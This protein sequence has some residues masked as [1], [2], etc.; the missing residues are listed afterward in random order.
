M[1]IGIMVVVRRGG[2]GLCC[3]RR[4]RLGRWGGI[5]TPS[6][7]IADDESL[8]LVITHKKASDQPMEN[9][10]PYPTTGLEEAQDERPR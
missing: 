4:R 7:T 6:S 9:A 5:F 3:G 10:G 8:V 2:R 1:R